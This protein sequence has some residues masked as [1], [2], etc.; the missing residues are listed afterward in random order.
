MCLKCG[1]MD[2]VVNRQYISNTDPYTKHMGPTFTYLTW[3]CPCCGKEYER[4][5]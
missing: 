3:K 4:L 5:S 2:E 1:V